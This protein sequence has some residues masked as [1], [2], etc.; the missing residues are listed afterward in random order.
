MTKLWPTRCKQK[1][2][3]QSP[4]HSLKK[5]KEGILPLSFYLASQK[6]DIWRAIR[7]YAFKNNISEIMGKNES[8]GFRVL[9]SVEPLHQP[10]AYSWEISWRWSYLP[11]FLLKPM[12]FWSLKQQLNSYSANTWNK[13][14]GGSQLMYEMERIERI[15]KRARVYP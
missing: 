15:G 5:K 10:T 11:S 12:L 4:C 2:Y 1:W 13:S 8:V 7:E 9:T 6:V 14:K 3:V